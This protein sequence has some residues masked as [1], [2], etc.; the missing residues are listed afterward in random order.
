[1]KIK[2][3]YWDFDNSKMKLCSKYE[4]RVAPCSKSKINITKLNESSCIW[5][6]FTYIS[7]FLLSFL[8]FVIKWSNQWQRV[9]MRCMK[10][11]STRAKKDWTQRINFSYVFSPFLVY[12]HSQLICIIY[13]IVYIYIM[14]GYVICYKYIVFW[15]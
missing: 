11:Q 10:W 2:F 1:M 6:S 5:N 13:I 7:F 4:K 8:S 12:S 3:E 9:V 14:Y 15:T